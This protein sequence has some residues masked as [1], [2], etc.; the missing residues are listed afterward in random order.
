M[1]L[2]YYRPHGDFTSSDAAV[3]QLKTG[4]PRYLL[5]GD[6]GTSDLWTVTRQLP[7]RYTS[8]AIKLGKRSQEH[9]QRKAVPFRENYDGSEM[10]PEVLPAKLRTF[11]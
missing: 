8:T 5:V 11:F 9:R 3:Q 6:P 1:T 4:Q 2:W 7:Q 10:G